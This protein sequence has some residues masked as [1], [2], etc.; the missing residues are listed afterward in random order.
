M[1]TDAAS[2]HFAA[3]SFVDRIVDFA[4]GRHAHGT[5]AIPATID[6]FPAALVAEAVGQLAAWVA[7]DWIDFRGRPVAALATE[8]RFS[9]V[10]APGQTLDL[11]VDILECDDDAVAY[12]GRASVGGVPAIELT[13]CLGPMLPVADFDA[14]GALRERLG[15]LRNGGTAPGRFGGIPALDVAVTH[16]V[17]GTE[18]RGTL[19][20]PGSA[21]FFADHFPRKPVFPATLLLDVQM[22]L[23]HR[24]ARERSGSAADSTRPVRATHVKMRSFIVPSQRV[25][26]AA[27]LTSIGD[28]LMKAMLSARTDDRLVATARLELAT[29]ASPSASVQ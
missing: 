3:Y 28:G 1:G 17:P 29:G 24:L 26:L 7:M 4:P 22:G 16:H 25:D 19:Q 2:H 20:V 14:P 18:I 5:F 6:A 9:A 10:A 27:E 21:P 11:D 8:T 15:V 13:D 23:A 12:N